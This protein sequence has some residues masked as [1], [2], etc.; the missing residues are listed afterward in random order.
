MG[1][2]APACILEAAGST[3]C[4]A[5]QGSHIGEQQRS[6]YTVLT[7]REPWNNPFRTI[8]PARREAARFPGHSRAE[9]LVPIGPSAITLSDILASTSIKSSF[10][11]SSD[12]PL[13]GLS[14]LSFLSV[15][16]VLSAIPRAGGL[17][18]VC[19]PVLLF[20]PL[21]CVVPF[22]CRPFSLPP[23]AVAAVDT[24]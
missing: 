18:V 9:P 7:H 1:G 5:V 2:E 16:L 11:S 14:G 23:P 10:T 12:C 19:S 17:I 21:S 3:S 6:C 8:I 24:N 4:P 20:L 22:S 13:H 15:H